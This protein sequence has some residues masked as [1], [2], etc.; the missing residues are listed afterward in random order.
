MY[1][2]IDVTVL[3]LGK[4]QRRQTLSAY[5]QEWH[6]GGLSSLEIKMSCLVISPEN[7]WP[8]ASLDSV[9]HD[10]GCT[11]PNGLLKIKCPCNYRDYTLFQAASQKGFCCRLEKGICCLKSTNTIIIIRCKDRWLAICSR[12]CCDLWF[13]Q[14]LGFLPADIC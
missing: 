9:V 12:K 1:V 5:K 14:M 2:P 11:D 3:C 7:S 4:G 13:L 6:K 8:G 10:P